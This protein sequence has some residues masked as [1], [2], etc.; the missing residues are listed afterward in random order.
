M[1]RWTIVGK[2]KIGTGFALLREEEPS[3]RKDHIGFGEKLI[4]AGRWV[5]HE[6]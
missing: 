2:L 6:K 5:Y 4:H 3:L 1:L